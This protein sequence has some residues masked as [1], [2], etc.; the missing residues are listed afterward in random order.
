MPDRVSAEVAELLAI[1]QQFDQAVVQADVARIGAILDEHWII[2]GPDGGTV[3]K[4]A[5]LAAIESGRLIHTSMASDEVLARSFGEAGVV[6]ARVITSGIYLGSPFRTVERST[7]VFV[8]LA[9]AWRCVLTHLT[10]IPDR[11]E[12]PG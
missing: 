10:T 6:T 4:L 5:F 12:G 1:E 2:V 7:D 11:G 9:G 3:T 8:R